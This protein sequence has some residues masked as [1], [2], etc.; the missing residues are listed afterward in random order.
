[1][2]QNTRFPRLVS[3]ACH[4]LRTP[5]ATVYGFARTLSR[6]D[7]PDP[8]PR[9]VEII[10][11]ASGQL[12][13]LLDELAL[14]AR[15]ESDRY[16]PTLVDADSLELVRLAAEELGDGAVA[17]S[18]EGARVRVEPEA[19]QRAIRQ[20]ARAAR[21]HGGVDSVRVNVRGRELEL[22]PITG[23]AAPVVTGEELRELGAAAAVALIRALGGSLALEGERLRIA[24][25]GSDAADATP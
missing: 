20:L 25:P 22:D 6:T 2:T 15:I 13:E 3:L 8:A 18:G 24:L 19:T 1:M 23:T 21:R 14:V 16:Q 10:E 11:A 12:A 17:V 5:L 9:Y 4:D 7:L